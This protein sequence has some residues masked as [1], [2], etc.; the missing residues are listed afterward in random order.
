MIATELMNSQKERNNPKHVM[1]TIKR[2][3]ESNCYKQWVHN[4]TKENPADN[5]TTKMTV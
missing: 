4:G 5:L 2:I 3:S 1:K